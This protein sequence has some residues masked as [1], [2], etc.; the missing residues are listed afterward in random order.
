MGLRS[1]NTR[2]RE[3]ILSFGGAGLGKSYDFYT[4]A[5]LALKTRSD[6]KF[7]VIDT[8]VSAWAVLSD[9]CFADLFDEDDNPKNIEVIEVEDWDGL[10]KALAIV[11]KKVTGRPQDWVMIDMISP[12]WDWVQSKF[13]EE[14]FGKGTDEYFL[15]ARKA[16]KADDKGPTGFEGWR[17]WPTINSMW[18]AFARDIVKWPSNLYCTGE[19]KKLNTDQAEKDTKVTFGP[20]GFTPVGQ[21]RLPHNFNTILW[22]TALKP[23]EY[24]MTTV[25]D[26]GRA[27]H[28]AITVDNFAKDYLVKTAG[29]KLV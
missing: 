2:Q 18:G 23:G 21:K 14:I 4:I 22:K 25:K 12:A 26:R 11:R 1:P 19:Q 8:D 17:D 5:Q 10:L 7:Y 6:A 15:Q 9:P 3:R 29:W 24:K 16:Q 20:W 13:S 28:K 27:Q